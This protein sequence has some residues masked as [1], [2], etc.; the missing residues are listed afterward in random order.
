MPALQDELFDRCERFDPSANVH[1]GPLDIAPR[2][3]L[4]PRADLG[5]QSSVHDLARIGLEAGEDL[6]LS[7]F[8]LGSV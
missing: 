7:I 3:A 2:A 8:A 1:S 6:L 4:D 5:L